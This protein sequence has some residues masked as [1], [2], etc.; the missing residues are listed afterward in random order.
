MSYLQAKTFIKQKKIPDRKWL[1]AWSM[2][3]AR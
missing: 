2:R 3:Y 1:E